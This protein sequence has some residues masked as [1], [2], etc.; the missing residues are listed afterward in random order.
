MVTPTP[1]QRLNQGVSCHFKILQYSP[2]PSPPGVNAG[3]QGCGSGGCPALTLDRRSS[4]ACIAVIADALATLQLAIELL[5]PARH[6]WLAAVALL[7]QEV[8]H[9]G[10]Q[11]L[12][13]LLGLACP[14]SQS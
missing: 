10:E 6:A 1:R 13:S 2:T 12:L 4:I 9:V 14:I 11:E 3:V 8:P 5:A 7:T